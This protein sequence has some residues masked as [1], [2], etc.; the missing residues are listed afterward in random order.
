MISFFRT[1]WRS[2]KGF[3]LLE[4]LIALVILATAGSMIML[5]YSQAIISTRLV[6]E[7]NTAT[8]L[9]RQQIEFL[10]QYE[11]VSGT[12][13]NTAY[14]F[15]GAATNSAT[16]LVDQTLPPGYRIQS[17]ILPAEKMNRV[18]GTVGSSKIDTNL[19]PI[20]EVPVE[21]TVSHNGRMVVRMKA[22]YKP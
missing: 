22:Y 9:A 14:R 18:D 2:E 13:Q 10:R 8:N 5:A 16:P 21:V 4:I 20:S 15:S 1:L 19:A 11:N 7:Q 12:G 17:V 6:N 3:S